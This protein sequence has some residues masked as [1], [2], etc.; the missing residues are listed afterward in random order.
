M[1]RRTRPLQTTKGTQHAAYAQTSPKEHASGFHVCQSDQMRQ[2][3][4]PLGRAGAPGRC[5]QRVLS[6]QPSM[7][8]DVAVLSLA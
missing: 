2:K 5:V 8:G 3:V 7:Q 6:V 1:C 4:L